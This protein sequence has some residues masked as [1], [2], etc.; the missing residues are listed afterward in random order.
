MKTLLSSYICDEVVSFRVFSKKWTTFALPNSLALL[1]NQSK[2]NCASN[3]KLGFVARTHSMTKFGTEAAGGYFR[4]VWVIRAFSHGPRDS[5]FHFLLRIVNKGEY[6]LR[7]QP[8]IEP[9][10]S[11]PSW[12]KGLQNVQMAFAVRGRT[13]SPWGR[14]SEWK[15][16]KGSR[17]IKGSYHGPWRPS[18]EEAEPY[19][20]S[21][22][23]GYIGYRRPPCARF[24][25]FPANF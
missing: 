23:L 13:W 18:K 20:C 9:L 6:P 10:S 7:A 14:N 4:V 3:L 11:P 22:P 5:L 8:L 17:E 2:C 1:Q 12:V 15:R 21:L 16:N 19:P 24:L 25:Y